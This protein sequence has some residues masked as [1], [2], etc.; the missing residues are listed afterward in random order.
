MSLMKAHKLTIAAALAAASVAVIGG[1][2]PVQASGPI[3]CDP[4]FYQVIAGQFAEFDPQTGA[5]SPIGADGE[6]YNAMAYRPADGYIYAIQGKKL[7]RI[8]NEGGIT[9]LGEVPIVSGAYTGDFGDDGRLHVSRGG[10]DWYAIDVDTLQAE[11]IAAFSQGYGVA[12]IANISG[13]F[14]GVSSTGNLYTFDPVAGVASNLGPVAGVS[15]TRKAFGAAWATAGNNFY[16]GRNSGEIYQ[17]TGY[18]TGEPVATRVL[19][20]PT[21]KSNDG[22]SCPYAPPPPGVPD[23]DGAE[24]EVPP[25]TPEGEEAAEQYE[26]EYEEPAYQVPDAGLGTGPSCES[27]GDVARE[28]RA[29][30]APISVTEAT[31]LYQND[32]G[33]NVNGLHITDGSWSLENGAFRQ[34]NTCGFDYSALISEHVVESFDFEATFHAVNDANQ[35]G[36]VFH[37]SSVNTRSGA[38]LVDLS[39]DGET[40]RWGYYDDDGYYQNVGWDFVPAPETGENVTLTIESRGA[41][42]TVYLNGTKITTQTAAQSGGMV[43][44]VT[45][46]SDVAFDNVVLT[47]VP[48]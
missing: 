28:S 17:I 5:Y 44:M 32:F 24:P 20:S 10:N 43:G 19:S 40:L 18:S 36:V 47:A 8:D 27:F 26:E 22:A 13:T 30:V 33:S 35:G 46:I 42:Y 6:N 14:Y 39:D 15:T 9:N 48:G 11:R 16:V 38:T 21:T 41:E 29:A 7:L 31:V 4:G 25:S 3:D 34:Q 2:S 1:S 23:V 37:Q 12:D 45:S